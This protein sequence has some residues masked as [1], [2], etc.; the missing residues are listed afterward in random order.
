[1]STPSKIVRIPITQRAET[2]KV[3]NEMRRRLILQ[4]AKEDLEASIRAA[5]AKYERAVARAVS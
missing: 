3:V 1:M 4:H 2:R 5:W